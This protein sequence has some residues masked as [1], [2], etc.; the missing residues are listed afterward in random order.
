MHAFGEH[1][2]REFNLGAD[3]LD[4]K[5]LWTWSVS[6]IE[7][8][9]YTFL[10]WCG[11]QH[12]GDARPVITQRTMPGAKWFTGIRLNY[13]DGLGRFDHSSN[14][15]VFRNESGAKTT[16]T[17][18]ELL[19]Q[20]GSLASALR[21]AGVSKGDRVAAYLPNIPECLV[22]FIATASLGAV[23]SSCSPDFGV[24]SVVD[25]FGQISPKILFTCDGYTYNGKAV[26]KLG[27]AELLARSLPSV[28]QVI[29]VSYANSREHTPPTMRNAVGFDELRSKSGALAPVK[30]EFEHPLW[31]LY[32]SGTTGLPKP[33]VQSHGG[34]ALEHLKSLMLHTNLTPGT[35]FF[36]FTTTGWMMWNL[37]VSGL[38]AGSA[39][40]LYDGSPTYPETDSL[41]RIA[42]EESI[43]LLGTSAP[44]IH[45]CMK[46]GLHPMSDYSLDKLVGV[47]STGAPLS[48]EGFEWCYSNVK[49]D[50][51]VASVS[52]GTDVCTAFVAGSP[53]L[54][55]YS[56][57]I[58]C[59]ALGANV[60]SFD[61][62]GNPLIDEVGELVVT[63]PMPSMPI[64][65]WGD[66]DGS[67]YRQ[68]YFEK[69]PGVW[70]HG[71]WIK[72][73]SRGTC[74]I[75]GRSDSTIKRF[76][77]R[78]GTSDFYRV[79]ERLPE[80]ADTLVVDLEDKDGSKV[81]LFVV[82]QPGS[83]LSEDL[84]EKI[85][86]ALKT[87]VSPRHVP[88]LIIPAPGVPKTLNGK[89]ME[90]PVKRILQGWPPEK[91]VNLDATANPAA[92]QFY[93][94][95]AKSLRSGSM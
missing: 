58:Q 78:M 19:Q 9:W 3:P 95:F 12:R 38:I 66:S 77:V 57:E 51:W 14:A 56:G 52:G 76:G 29:H 24:P 45:L 63:E 92:V 94:S 33:I 84:K 89:K 4:Y 22:G 75:Y 40:T 53:T 59:R 6:N 16:L 41:W 70:R 17:R 15:V 23:W 1:V 81:I 60:Q 21:D 64:Y 55:V 79:V 5:D 34:I 91:A 39:V 62:A 72:I 48:P 7:D 2:R 73:T 88:D 30:V 32:S 11:L 25:R 28:R 47:G 20:A 44:Y 46:M 35:N 54:P 85:R 10:T 61:E 8:F 26:D 87:Q 68:S 27:D 37:L 67:R 82:L 69:Y 90:V 65:F 42:E 93:L 43:T 80:V 49:H 50:L 36:W 71:D 13:A 83:D 31:V 86:T 74:I 18:G